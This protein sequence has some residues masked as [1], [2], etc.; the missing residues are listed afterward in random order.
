VIASVDGDAVSGSPDVARLVGTHQPGDTIKVQVR[1][2]GITREFQV[3]L[4]TRPANA[5]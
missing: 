5:P 1:R 2:G 3:H 4:S